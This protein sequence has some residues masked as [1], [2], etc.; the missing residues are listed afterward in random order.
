MRRWR[1]K[2]AG[3]VTERLDPKLL[4]TDSGRAACIAAWL[5][6]IEPLR[7]AK[8]F[9]IEDPYLIHRSIGSF[10]ARCGVPHS[11]VT[12]SPLADW[13][14]AAALALQRYKSGQLELLG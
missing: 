5:G 4:L 9:D 3:R 10:I 11:G 8:A 6:G 13:K 2:R 12:C 1:R 14:A 7:I